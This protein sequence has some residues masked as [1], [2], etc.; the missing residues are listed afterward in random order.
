[1]NEEVFMSVPAVGRRIGVSPAR[2]Y[3]MAAAGVFPTVKVGGRIVCPRSAFEAWLHDQETR[4]LANVRLNPAAMS[5][6]EARVEEL[7]AEIERLRAVEKAA[8]EHAEY[9]EQMD[10]CDGNPCY[11]RAALGEVKP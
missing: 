4:A 11:L 2:A 7:E 5:R 1:M 6:L 9:D 3:A 10:P 8:R